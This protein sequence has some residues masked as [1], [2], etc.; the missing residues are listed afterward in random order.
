MCN[1]VTDADVAAAL[2]DRKVRD[3][4]AVFRQ[5]YRRRLDP[6]ECESTANYALFKALMWWQTERANG[7]QFATYLY[8]TLGWEFNRRVEQ[9]GRYQARRQLADLR[10]VP[11]RDPEGPRRP[12]RG[13][14][15]EYLDRYLSRRQAAAF[16]QFH[17]EGRSAQEIGDSLGWTEGQVRRQLRAAEARLREV[18]D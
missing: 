8:T 12:A 10:H 11:A 2:A 4:L 6:D 14:A 18:I 15:G 16:R 13:D 1:T 17:V 5:R 9:E 3:Y 7:G